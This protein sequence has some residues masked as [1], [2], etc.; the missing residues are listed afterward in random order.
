L[1]P[2]GT[3]D[4]EFNA[5]RVIPEAPHPFAVL[6]DGKLLLGGY[7][8]RSNNSAR[9][10]VVRL[11]HDGSI[12]PT[13]TAVFGLD[14]AV[15]ALAV[16]TNGQILVGGFLE[17]LNGT[18]VTNLVR[19]TADGSVDVAYR[20]PALDLEIDSFV[21]QPDGKLILH[22][23]L[24][25]IGGLPRDQFKRLNEDG[26]LDARFVGPP[27]SGFHVRGFALLSENKLLCRRL[28][29]LGRGIGFRGDLARYRSDWTLDAN[30][31]VTVENTTGSLILRQSNGK[32]IVVDLLIV[33]AVSQG[34]KLLA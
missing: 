13:F 26:S 32:L 8:V 14:D 30:F 19:L 24:T 11:N 21:L 20:P 7:I 31:N 16:Q 15:T 3:L 4:R 1:N 18:A 2:D 25:R 10:E 33:R 23:P 27:G 6:P 34:I 9:S 29:D 17:E 28:F 5:P 12:D 22:G